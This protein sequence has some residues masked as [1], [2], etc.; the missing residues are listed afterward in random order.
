MKYSTKELLNM[1][2]IDIIDICHGNCETKNC[3]FKKSLREFREDGFCISQT[4]KFI[5]GWIEEDESQIKSLE[6]KKD[7]IKKRIKKYK[8]WKKKIE[9]EIFQKK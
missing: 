5:D 9:K 2:L 7:T 1:N 8:N 4:Y 6:I 3:L